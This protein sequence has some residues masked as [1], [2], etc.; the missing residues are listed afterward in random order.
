MI[1]VVTVEMTL[2]GLVP[3]GVKS[4]VKG[5]NLRFLS[6]E[7]ISSETQQPFQNLLKGLYAFEKT[8]ERGPQS[9]S[10]Y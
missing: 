6:S 1:P 9:T 3:R 7:L 8:P 2:W 5:L 4:T 10:E